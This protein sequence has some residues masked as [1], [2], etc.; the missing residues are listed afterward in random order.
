[1]SN[2]RVGLLRAL[3]VKRDMVNTAVLCILHPTGNGMQRPTTAA[4]GDIYTQVC[5]YRSHS[6][7]QVY[8]PPLR[9]P[10]CLPLAGSLRGVCMSVVW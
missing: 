2:C 5:S 7:M 9:I 1:M 8:F 4:C 10:E 3:E 6:E